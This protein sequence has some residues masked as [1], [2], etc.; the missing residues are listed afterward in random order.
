MVR[1]SERTN[2]TPIIVETT[3]AKYNQGKLKLLKYTYANYNMAN[4]D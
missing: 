3:N 4:L 1:T 2:Y